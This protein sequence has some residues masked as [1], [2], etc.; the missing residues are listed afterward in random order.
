MRLNYLLWQHVGIA[1]DLNKGNYFIV[2]LLLPCSV[3]VHSFSR[4]I[5]QQEG[6]SKCDI[7]MNARNLKVKLY[8]I[9][10]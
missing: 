5:K 8:C 2:Y 6:R 10:R 7:L 1:I 9:V 3:W 4:H